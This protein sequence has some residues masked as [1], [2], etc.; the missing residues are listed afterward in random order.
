MKLWKVTINQLDDDQPL[1]TYWG[2]AQNAKQAVELARE[3]AHLDSIA[4]VKELAESESL[5][6]E[7]IAA[8]TQVE[9]YASEVVLI[10]DVEFGM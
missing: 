4:A 8:E 10:G 2:V 5:S 9:L 3:R 6:A 1:D 7:E